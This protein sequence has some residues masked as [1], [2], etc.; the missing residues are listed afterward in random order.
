MKSVKQDSKKVEK[1]WTLPCLV[2]IN[3]EDTTLSRKTY[4]VVVLATNV[5]GG[6]FDGFVVYPTELYPKM[7][8]FHTGF[9]KSCFIKYEGNIV[10]SN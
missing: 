7:G 5:R 2:T 1:G 8:E 3:E 4:G 9:A 6:E 10:L